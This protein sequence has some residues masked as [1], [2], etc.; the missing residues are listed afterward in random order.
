VAKGSRVRAMLARRSVQGALIFS[1]LLAVYLA[2][3]DILEGNDAAGNVRLAGKVVSKHKLVFTPEEDP[4]MFDW[5]LKTPEGE[6]FAQFHSWRSSLKGEPIR[7]AYER[8][9]LG[10]PEPCYYLTRTRVPGVYANR[11]GVGA[12]LFAIPFVAAV[13]P[14]ARDLYDRPSAAILWHTTKVASACAVAASAVLLFL[15]ALPFLR[16]KTAAWLALA[17]G[18]G[19]CVWSA[20]SQ[21]LWQHGPTEFFLALGTY[22]LM[23]R[24]R[25]RAAYWVGL[26][27]ALAFVCRPTAALVLAAVGIS[28][29]LRDRRALLRCVAGALPAVLLLAAYNLHVFGRLIVLGQMDI[30]AAATT[31]AQLPPAFTLVRA[32][33]AAGTLD[34]ARRYVGTSLLEGLAGILVSPS[35]GL[36]VFSPI[37]AFGFWGVLHTYR[38]SRFSVLRPVGLTALALCLVVALWFNWWGGWCYGPRLLTDA[39]TLLAFLAIPVAEEIRQSRTLV[40]V[41][42]VC[43]AWA[44]AVQA[45]GAFA[46]DVVGWNNRTLFAVNLPGRAM[47]LL[48]TDPNEAQRE[49]RAHGGSIKERAIN[50]DFGEGRSRLWSIRDSQILYYFEHFLEARARKRLG[51]ENF[52]RRQG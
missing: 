21:T 22:F 44:V 29:F 34:T 7:R 32:A 50:V 46:Y 52:L 25:P 31:S 47:P 20:S 43:L 28:Y 33:A 45:V 35:R 2:N 9:E 24:E 40:V 10:K 11:Y 12:S 37:V 18:L 36:L 1:F 13:Y 42:G 4:F 23:Q 49:A 5:R 14:F 26:S 6:R 39:V 51:S 30:G 8:G 19:T 27:Y 41:F 15:A 48:F 16:P 38:D 17:Y 3:G